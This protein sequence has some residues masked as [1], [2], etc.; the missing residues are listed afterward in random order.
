MKTYDLCVAWNWEYD[1]DFI[2]M[3][4][5][6][7][8]TEDVSILTVLPEE[9]ESVVDK[10]QKS[11]ISIDAYFDRA[12]DTD[13]RFQTLSQWVRHHTIF[14]INPM[15][16]AR[17]A[18]N[19]ATMHLDFITAGLFTPYT[20]ILPPF[21]EQPMLESIDL[22]PLS[23]PFI[24]KPAHG[25]GGYGV[26]ME[27]T[28]I[29]QVQSARRENPADHYLLQKKI[30]P[31]VNDGRLTWFRVIYYNG[32][33][34]PCWWATDTH[35]YTPVT[36]EEEQRYGLTPLRQIAG[37]ISRICNLDLFSTE[38]A[39]TPEGQFIVV[40][41]LNDPIDLRLKSKAKDGI[42]DETVRNICIESIR[43]VQNKKRINIS[44]ENL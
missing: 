35:I 27:A 17:R 32:K 6:I 4:T 11:E 25:G 33:T 24:I 26:I 23:T 20:I 38:I 16:H 43:L 28:A 10:I 14:E 21:R 39:L 44:E 40:D 5:A 34:S 22:Q 8:Q 2:R 13:S 15:E 19:K 3:L 37:E 42:P 12:S 18:W 1:E 7:G 36:M 30:I 41:Y 31:A 9:I 29:D